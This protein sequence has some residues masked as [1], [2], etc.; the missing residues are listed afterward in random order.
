MKIDWKHL[1]NWDVVAVKAPEEVI[2]D[3]RSVGY[4]VVVTYKYHGVDTEF[5]SAD[6][7][8]MYTTYVNPKAAAQEAYRGHL[9]S[10]RKQ[11]ER[12]A[13]RER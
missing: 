7:E 11:I 10:M 4:K 8:R 1:F 6:D 13:V 2:L 12:A 3:G 9:H 5:Y